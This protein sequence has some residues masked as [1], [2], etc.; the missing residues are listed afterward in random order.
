MNVHKIIRA[1]FGSD[2]PVF[3][4]YSLKERPGRIS[5]PSTSYLFID[6]ATQRCQRRHPQYQSSSKMGIMRGRI[7]HRG[8]CCCWR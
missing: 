4:N 1:D 7:L 6:D 5:Y 2:L 3:T 8:Y